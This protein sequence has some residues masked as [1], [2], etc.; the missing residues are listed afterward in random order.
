MDRTSVKTGSVGRLLDVAKDY[1]EL[2]KPGITLSVVASMLIGFIM[3]T[4]GTLNYTLMFHA[5][6]GTY[7]IAAGTAAHNMFMERGLD[8][9]MHRTS[10]RPLPDSRISSKNSLI[11]SATLIF[12]GLF[13]LI[14]L[15]NVVAGV[16]SLATT[17]I[18]LFAYTP[19][20]RISALNVFVGAIP[21]ALPVVGG[22]AAATGTVFEH[23]MWILFGI[24]FCWQVPH[25]IAIAWVCRKDYEHAGFKMLPK[26]DPVGIKAAAWVLIPILI[27]FPTVY[28]LYVM[29]LVSWIYLAG[30]LL[31]TLG[32]LWYGVQFAIKRDI[33]TAKGVM[34]YSFAYLPLIWI[35]I[36]SDWMIL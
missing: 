19:L 34:F 16:V 3:G 12:L 24:V 21:G 4:A 25:V 36:Y 30:S 13:Y 14:A 20:K 1:Y 35:F 8:G 28:K 17:I 23:G 2:T 32:F 22:W 9:L 6:L 27:L 26:N 7:L 11:F 18:Y 31:T 10:K 29:D 5:L 15:V 33:V